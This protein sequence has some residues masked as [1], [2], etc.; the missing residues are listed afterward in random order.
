MKLEIKRKS[1]KNIEGEGNNV[2]RERTYNLRKR[3]VTEGILEITMVFGEEEEMAIRFGEVEKLWLELSQTGH[4]CFGRVSFTS[5][6][7]RA[8]GEAN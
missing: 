5:A 8:I 1:K 4:L 6:S 3:M 7:A 2:Q